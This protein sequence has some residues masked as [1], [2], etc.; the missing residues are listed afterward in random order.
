MATYQVYLAIDGSGIKAAI[1]IGWESRQT[2]AELSREFGSRAYVHVSD[3]EAADA[4][5]ALDTVK[6]DP[7]PTV[8]AP[9]THPVAPAPYLGQR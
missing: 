7:R 6:T 9:I 8:R 4:Q 3:V 1:P 5:A 2:Q